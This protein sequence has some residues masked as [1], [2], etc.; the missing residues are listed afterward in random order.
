MPVRSRSFLTASA[1]MSAML[2]CPFCGKSEIRN[3]K[4]ESKSFRISSFGF[5]ISYLLLL[6]DRRRR[7]R[8]RG[9]RA[10]AARWA[11]RPR[12]QLGLLLRRQ[13]SAAFEDGVGQLAEYQLNR[14]NAVVVAG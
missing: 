14:A 1:V 13:R 9:A 4:S 5:R 12:F 11:G 2:P 6:Y 3:S 8:V 7:S 10:V